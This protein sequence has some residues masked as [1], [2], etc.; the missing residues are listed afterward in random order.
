[1]SCAK[2]YEPMEMPFGMLS[3]VAPIN[4]VLGGVKMP[5]QEG[6]LIGECLTHALQSIGFQGIE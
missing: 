2:T 1:V 3:S 6:I 4:Y 5:Q